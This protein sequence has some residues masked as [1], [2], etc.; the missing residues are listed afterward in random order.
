VWLSATMLFAAANVVWAT[1]GIA[2]LQRLPRRYTERTGR[3]FDGL[4][5]LLLFQAVALAVTAAA[6][7]LSL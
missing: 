6:I 3:A 4:P 5:A 2:W 1:S 7:T